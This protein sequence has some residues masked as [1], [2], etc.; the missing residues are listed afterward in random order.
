MKTAELKKRLNQES[1]PAEKVKSITLDDRVSNGVRHT[2][3][4]LVYGVGL[5]T[6]TLYFQ[7]GSWFSIEN[8][9]INRYQLVKITKIIE[10]WLRA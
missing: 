5:T 6:V 7:N 1:N 9:T 4:V 3:V 10:E 2:T 8:G